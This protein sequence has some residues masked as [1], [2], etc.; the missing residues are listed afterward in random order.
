KSTIT[1][2]QY[3]YEDGGIAHEF[4]EA[5]ADRC[6]AG[7]SANILLDHQGSQ[8][9]PSD[10]IK[11]MKNAGCH[12]EYFRRVKVEGIIFPWKLLR[13]NY[14]SHRRILVIDGRIGFTG[15][16]GQRQGGGGKG[17]TP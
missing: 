7:V 14:R 3:L 6:R 16:D 12:V 4:A 11:T 9:A 13:Y 10:I 8:K 2:A 1:M 15:G 5:F 17:G